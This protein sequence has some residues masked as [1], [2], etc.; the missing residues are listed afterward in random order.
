MS[1]YAYG[2]PGLEIQR[3]RRVVDLLDKHAPGWRGK[4]DAFLGDYAMITILNAL[5]PE[6]HARVAPANTFYVVRYLSTD[7]KSDAPSY[8]REKTTS[9]AF[10]TLEEAKAKALEWATK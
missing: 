8:R 6:Q 1:E 3:W 9:N 4:D 7:P 5:E 2:N 10:D